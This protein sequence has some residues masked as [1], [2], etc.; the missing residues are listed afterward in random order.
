MLRS[1]PRRRRR[2]P[3]TRQQA[4]SLMP[5]GG[6]RPVWN[7][8]WPASATT[9]RSPSRWTRA[10]WCPFSTTARFDEPEPSARR[11]A[12]TLRGSRACPAQAESLPGAVICGRDPDR[13]ALTV[14]WGRRRV[15]DPAAA[16]EPLKVGE[17][18]RYSRRAGVG[19]LV[20]LTVVGLG[21]QA[22]RSGAE[23]GPAVYGMLDSPAPFTGSDWAPP[24]ADPDVAEAAAAGAT[25]TDEACTF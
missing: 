5:S 4:R 3:C 2:V 18:M 14:R 8:R 13:S 16:S 12:A 21:A 11:A 23:E 7:S 20:A 15:A 1:R 9:S 19:A 25:V 17:S 22:A 10:T 6:A 24:V